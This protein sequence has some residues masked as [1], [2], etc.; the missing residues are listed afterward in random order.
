MDKFVEIKASSVELAIEKALEELQTS[1]E[2][3]DIEIISKGGLFQ[4]AQV[5]V[6]IKHVS[7]CTS[8]AETVNNKA[9]ADRVVLKECDFA[10]AN[11]AENDKSVEK[12]K[13]AENDK[14]VRKEKK[15]N[16]E[17]GAKVADFVNGILENMK[18]VSR[19]SVTEDNENVY[20]EIKG[21]DSGTAIGYRGEALDA[22]QYL[23]LTFLN[24]ER[25]D[26]KKV[27]VDCEDYREKRKETLIALANRLAE[28]AQR[29]ARK[30][31]LEPMNPFERR[32]IHSALAD[33]EIA[34]TSSE[35]EEPNRYVVITPKGVELKSD[36]VRRE[37]GRSRDRGARNSGGFNGRRDGRR[38]SRDGFRS[39]RGGYKQDNKN[40]EPRR[41][42]KQEETEVEDGREF[43][44]YYTTDFEKTEDFKKQGAPKFKS[45]GGP[46]RP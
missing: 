24:Q 43:R 35:G 23:V 2:N 1:R 42:P 32:I 27:V 34:S 15:N 20:V 25:C 17:V 41:E 10:D 45:F 44:G 21:E 3:V 33:S 22:I 18:L 28:K 38:D 19:A 30:V 40:Y 46:K 13:S 4:K 11:A 36:R 16:P 9:V 5:R 31:A 12:D 14:S 26:F 6:S 7:D 29:T 8:K 37:D 39:G